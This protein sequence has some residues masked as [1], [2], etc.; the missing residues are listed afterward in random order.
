MDKKQL[1]DELLEII[2]GGVLKDRIVFHKKTIQ[3]I[4]N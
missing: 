1:E 3:I 2:N 4:Y